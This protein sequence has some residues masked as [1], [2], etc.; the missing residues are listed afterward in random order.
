MARTGKFSA[1]T[2][3]LHMMLKVVDL[4]TFGMPTTPAFTWLVGRPRITRGFSSC[5][6]QAHRVVR[7]HWTP[8]LQ[9][10]ASVAAQLARPRQVG[11]ARTSFFFG[12]IVVRLYR[13]C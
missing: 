9:T 5:N 2:D 8:S 1:G 13:P 10:D 3:I 6:R 11:A 4:P 12:A 7:S